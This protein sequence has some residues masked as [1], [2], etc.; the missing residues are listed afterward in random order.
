[1]PT[2]TLKDK[3][4]LYEEEYRKIKNPR[5]EF[6]AQGLKVFLPFGYK[7]GA[8]DLIVSHSSWVYKN[9]LLFEE[10]FSSLSDLPLNRFFPRNKFLDLAR[11][12]AGKYAAELKLSLAVVKIRSMRAR[13]GSCNCRDT[14]TLNARLRF[15]PLRFL[16]YVAFHEVLHLRYRNHGK[17]FRACMRN[18]FPDHKNIDRQLF[19]YDLLL[20]KENLV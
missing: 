7:K 20:K 18:R 16:C 6:K 9:A 11:D 17:R 19:S 1:M 3:I 2:I 13:W 12:T 10:I 5:L 4:I 14:V 8:A 15:L